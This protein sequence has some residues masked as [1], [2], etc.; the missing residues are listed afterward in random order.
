M[1]TAAVIGCGR[2]VQVGHLLG[3]K[4]VEEQVRVVAVADP[5]A[6]NPDRKGAGPGR[7][8]PAATGGG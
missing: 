7:C 3:L 5:V 8:L 6:E 1:L 2:V 4:E